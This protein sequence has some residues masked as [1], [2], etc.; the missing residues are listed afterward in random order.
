MLDIILNLLPLIASVVLIFLFRYLD[1]QNRSV[2]LAKKVV[3]EAKQDFEKYLK[4]NTSKLQ[5]VGTELE[6]KQS[7]AIAAIKRLESIQN[8]VGE[9]TNLFQDKINSISTFIKNRLKNSL[10]FRIQK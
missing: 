2:E 9:K 7:V 8:E 6:T 4:E 5:D 1:R 10:W 3:A